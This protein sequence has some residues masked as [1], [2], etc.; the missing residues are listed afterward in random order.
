MCVTNLL[1]KMVYSSL[2][3][4]L[5]KSKDF[6]LMVPVHIFN[7]KNVSLINT[8]SSVQVSPF[9]RHDNWIRDAV[10]CYLSF[11]KHI[12]CTASSVPIYTPMIQSHMEFSI[13]VHDV[14]CTLI[15]N[16]V[17]EAL[18]PGSMCLK[19]C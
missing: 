9:R 3:Q 17:W 4:E 7:L 6:I 18:N 14:L 8:S 16:R 2:Q 13:P 11:P 15:S 5:A 1:I 12:L 10:I 19:G